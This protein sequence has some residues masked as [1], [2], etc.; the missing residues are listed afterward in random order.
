MKF[1][2]HLGVGV[3][4]AAPCPIHLQPAFADC[5]WRRG[6]F[7]VAEALASSLLSLFFT[8]VV[9]LDRPGVLIKPRRFFEGSSARVRA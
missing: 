8:D 9:E 2:R 4:C 1:L 3:W 7:P 6:Q 5:G